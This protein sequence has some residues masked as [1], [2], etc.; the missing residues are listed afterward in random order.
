VNRPSS[1]DEALVGTGFNYSAQERARQSAVLL[2]VMPRVRDIRRFGAAALD[3][4]WTAA[5]RLDAFFERGLERWDWAAGALLVTEAGGVARFIDAAPPRP[6]G[7][8]A[9]HP[10][11]VDDVHRL[12]EDPM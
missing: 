9:A 10:D 6:A 2:R 4:A 12:F 5:G 1:L 11:L 8:V 3:L 7:M